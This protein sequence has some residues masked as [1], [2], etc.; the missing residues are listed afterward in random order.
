MSRME[1]LCRMNWWESK[2]KLLSPS[3]TPWHNKLECLLSKKRSGIVWYLTV[4]PDFAKVERLSVLKIDR[5]VTF[6]EY[7]IFSGK[8]SSLFRRIVG[9]EG[10][11]FYDIDSLLVVAAMGLV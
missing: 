4:T 6:L 2:K 3:Q 9:E 7:K 11:K 1:L 5:L 10:G 8:H